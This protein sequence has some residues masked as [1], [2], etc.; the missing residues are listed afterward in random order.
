MAT[1]PKSGPKAAAPVAK[2]EAPEVSLLPQID[3]A[4]KEA[5]AR[6]DHAS[7]AVLADMQV[8]VGALKHKAQGAASRLQGFDAA[9]AEMVAQ[10]L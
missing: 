1:N 5:L 7:Y 8:A 4:V 9:L 2:K 10:T 3:D 6:G